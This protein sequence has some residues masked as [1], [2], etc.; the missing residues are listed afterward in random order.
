MSSDG[1]SLGNYNKFCG[2]LK[3]GFILYNVDSTNLWGE[4]LLVANVTAIR[5]NGLKTYTVL[6]IGLKK[7]ENKFIP[8]NLSI[9]M[10][11]D[12][13][14][15]IP[16]LKYVGKCEFRL[17]PDLQNVEVSTGLIAAY[18]STDLHKFASK[19]AAIEDAIYE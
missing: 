5:L 8:Y 13:A 14:S 7:E 1:V 19:L 15:N 4:Y 3:E 6:M 17:I 9:K 11:P 10:T 18:G 12:Y 2:N 16:F